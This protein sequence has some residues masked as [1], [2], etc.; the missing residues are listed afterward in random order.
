ML[1]LTGQLLLLFGIGLVV[2]FIN[3][4]AGGGSLLSLPVLIFLGLPSATANGTNR[5]GILL[6]N[7]VAIAGFQRQHVMPWRVSLLAAVPAVAGSIIGARWAIALPE[8]QFKRALALTMIGVLVV[9]LADPGKRLHAT[10]RPLTGWRRLAF[11]AGFFGVGVFGGFIQAG[12]GFLIILVMALAGFDLVATN[13]VK[14][15]VVFIFTIAALYVFI[16]HDHVDYLLGAGLGLG[17]ALGGYLGTR[18]TVRKGH[19]WIRGFVVV[20]VIAFSLYLMW[21]SLS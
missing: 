11:M 13:A 21:D 8:H 9:I 4:L 12:V 6:Q 2:G 14:V 5:I 10:P 15:I 20:V 18:Y 1:S 3:V 19:A 7:V 17:N 16:R